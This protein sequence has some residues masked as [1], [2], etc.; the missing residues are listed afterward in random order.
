M[1]EFPPEGFVTVGGEVGE[2]SLTLSIGG[3]HLDPDEVTRILGITPSF[4]A[5]KGDQR[6]AGGGV[7]TQRTGIWLL[8]LTEAPSPEWTLADAIETLLSRLPSDLEVWKGLA[9]RFEVSLSCGLFLD[10]WNQGLVLPTSLLRQIADR[11]LDLDLDI[12]CNAE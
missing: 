4:A 6:A 10:G 1:A 12:Y 8:R 2:I 7:V 5:R 3:D 11:H 9:A